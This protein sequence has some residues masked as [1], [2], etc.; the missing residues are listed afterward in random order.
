MKIHQLVFAI[1]SL[2][3][4]IHLSAAELNTLTEAEKN[5]GWMLLFDGHSLTGWRSF[6]TD[7]PGAGWK[8]Q[9]GALVTA[10]NAGDLMTTRVFGDFEMTF[11]WKISEGGNSG[12]IYRIA[13]GE[14]ATYRTGPE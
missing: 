1:L 5:A 3:T 8:V 9:D 14:A 4:G 6:R 10:G 13:L 7:T 11:D 2:L 12:V